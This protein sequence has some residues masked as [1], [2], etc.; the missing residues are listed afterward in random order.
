[1]GHPGGSLVNFREWEPVYEAVLADFGYD[2]AA[3]ERARDRLARTLG[4]ETFDPAGLPVRGASVAIAGAGD[5]LG[6]ELA[7]AREADLVVA[8]STAADRLREAGVFVDCMV[9][10][11][12]KNP[13][14]ARSLTGDGVP[15]AVHAHGDNLGAIGTVVPSLDAAAV[16]PTTQARPRGDTWNFGG[17]TDGDRAAFLADHLGAAELT[18]PG[19]DFDDPSVGREKARKLDWAERLLYWL[20]RRRGDRF[21]VLDGRRDAL[22][23]TGLPGV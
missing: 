6:T 7:L 17:F 22:D 18:F 9:T 21:A 12:D 19:W 14:T 4:S 13:E 8:A 20:E 16:M 11:L 1:M 2:R 3:D 5:T 15:V 23:V 10:D